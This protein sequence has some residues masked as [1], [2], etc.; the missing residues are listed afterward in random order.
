MSLAQSV[1]WNSGVRLAIT[2]Q[3]EIYWVFAFTRYSAILYKVVFE[4]NST[5]YISTG[6]TRPS[7]FQGLGSLHER[8]RRANER[9][10]EGRL[11]RGIS[12]PFLV[13]LSLGAHYPSF[14]RSSPTTKSLEQTRSAHVSY[15]SLP[16]WNVSPHTLWETN[17][18]QTQAL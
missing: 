6:K 7:L 8:E 18:L 16:V 12:L 1:C 10:N 14:Y 15:H 17:R 11:T 3:I 13:F 9:N 5:K 2:E 4:W